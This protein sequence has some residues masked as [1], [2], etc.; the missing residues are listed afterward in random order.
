LLV[1]VRSPRRLPDLC[2]QSLPVRAQAGDPKYGPPI[3]IHVYDR[4]PLLCIL[5]ILQRVVFFVD[6]S[7]RGGREDA[8]VFVVGENVVDFGVVV[9]ASDGIFDKGEEGFEV[10]WRCCW[11]AVVGFV[12]VVAVFSR[13]LVGSRVPGG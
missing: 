7:Q 6:R 5:A 10:G 4:H 2:P 8:L 11:R 9:F 1:I 13:G 12:V 3:A